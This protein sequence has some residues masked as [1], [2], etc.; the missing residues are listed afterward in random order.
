M[1]KYLQNHKP[2]WKKPQFWMACLMGLVLLSGGTYYY[3]AQCSAQKAKASDLYDQLMISLQTEKPEEGRQSAQTLVAHYPKTIYAPFAALFLAKWDVEHKDWAAAEK[4]LRFVLQNTKKSPLPEIATL[5]LARVLSE[6]KKHA[7]A[8]SLLDNKKL[9][10]SYVASYEETKGDIY[11]LQEN[12]EQAR[13]AY[14]AAAKAL[15]PGA[16]S[17]GRLQLKQAA[18][19]LKQTMDEEGN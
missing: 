9:G 16:A 14:L 15:P 3:W 6:Q 1:M 19:G 12:I 13:E 11:W 10:S 4:Q 2:Y 17:A 5:R 18:L 8:L 7:E